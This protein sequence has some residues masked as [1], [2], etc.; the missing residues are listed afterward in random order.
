MAD[1][2]GGAR[3]PGSSRD[4]LRAVGTGWEQSEP[5]GAGCQPVP[6]EGTGWRTGSSCGVQDMPRKIKEK[7][8]SR[9]NS[10]YKYKLLDTEKRVLYRGVWGI[11][12][13]V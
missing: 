4:W 5:L 9:K 12:K 7:T 3:S 1:Q 11:F 6:A 8:L 2:Q 10:F 13:L